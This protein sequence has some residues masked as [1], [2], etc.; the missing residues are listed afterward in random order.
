MNTPNT[1][2]GRLT[3]EIMRR[4]AMKLRGIEVNTY[5]SIYSSVLEVLQEELQGKNEEAESITDRIMK[6]GK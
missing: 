2:A 6:G 4:V 1:K 5:N 3:E